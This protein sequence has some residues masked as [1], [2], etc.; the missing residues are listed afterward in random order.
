MLFAAI[1]ASAG[2][3]APACP[4][5]VGAATYVKQQI[6]LPGNNAVRV[7]CIYQHAGQPPDS[8]PT[9]WV[10][11]VPKGNAATLFYGCGQNQKTLGARTYGD[12]TYNVSGQFDGALAL[13]TGGDTVWKAA[14]LAFMKDAELFAKPCTAVGATRHTWSFSSVGPFHVVTGERRD[15][16]ATIT[17]AAGSGT[18]EVSPA[19]SVTKATG[20]LALTLLEKGGVRHYKLGV[21]TG[22]SFRR[23]GGTVDRLLVRVHVVNLKS[24]SVDCVADPDGS[25]GLT[26]GSGETQDVFVVQTLCGLEFTDHKVRVNIR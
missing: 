6:Y 4:T 24:S 13:A 26:D 17:S 1:D 7:Q 14:T 3:P 8:N 23:S 15:V 20:S 10:D 18:I 19:G 11:F 22:V 2:T 21:D 16:T 12:A 5:T 9:M 25:I